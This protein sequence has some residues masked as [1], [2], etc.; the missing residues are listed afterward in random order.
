MSEIMVL[1]ADNESGVTLSLNWLFAGGR[2]PARG[3][4]RVGHNAGKD[5]VAWTRALVEAALVML[6]GL[7]IDVDLYDVSLV[8]NTGDIIMGPD[9][10][11]CLP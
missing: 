4:V 6:T 2:R 5:R 7:T 11:R 8:S 3:Y 1:C 10:V 9:A